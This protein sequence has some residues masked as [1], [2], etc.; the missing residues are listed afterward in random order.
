ME[1]ALVVPPFLA[2]A[3]MYLIVQVFLARIRL[4]RSM[5]WPSTRG[6]ILDTSIE[7]ERFPH[8]V[9]GGVHAFKLQYEYFVAGQRFVGDQLSVNPQLSTS[10]RSRAEDRAVEYYP[11][12]EV[13]VFYNPAKPQQAC[14]ERTLE[15]EWFYWMLAVGLLVVAVI[16]AARVYAGGGGG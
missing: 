7:I 8:E 1:P 3:A 15:G 13:T 5:D 12:A 9:S 10:F 6:R 2:L 14:L 11:R 4:A 16:V